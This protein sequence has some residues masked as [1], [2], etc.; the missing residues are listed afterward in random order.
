MGKWIAGAMSLLVIVGAT[1]GCS[2]S[3]GVEKYHIEGVVTFQGNA[4]PVGSI[5]FQPDPSQGNSGPYGVAQIKDGK[6]STKLEG[7]AIVGGPHLVIIEAFDGKN[8]N[9]DYAPYGASIGST[10]QERFDLPKQDSTLEIE[11]TD[12]KKRK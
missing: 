3:D 2:Q 11:L 4:V 6:F 9:P 5:V 8:V 12:R 1:G 10:Y 7:E